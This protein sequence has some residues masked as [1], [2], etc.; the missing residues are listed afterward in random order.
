MKYPYY[1]KLIAAVSLGLGSLFAGAQALASAADGYPAKPIKISI[2]FP[3]GGSTDGPMRVLAE[4]ASR[5]L[6]Q[7]IVIENRTG[8]GG[9]LAALSLQSAASDGYTLAVAPIGIYRVP[10]VTNNKFDPTQDLTYVIGITGYA[11]GIVVPAS[12]PI[13]TIQ[14]YIDEARRNPGRLTYGTPGAATTNHLT[15]E[16]FSRLAGVELN[17]IPFKGSADSLQALLGGHVDSAAET[18]AWAPHVK[19]GQMRL[20]AVWGE[21]R[22]ASFP[23]APTLRE[24]GIDLVQTS[25]WG[26]VAPKGTDP[27]IVTKVHDAFRQA[28]Q[29]DAFK[30]ALAQFDMEPEYRGPQQYHEYAVRT[31]QEQKALLEELGLGN[32]P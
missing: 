29:T 21:K 20:L 7:P 19:A 31:T 15:M 16:Q 30:R 12:S 14:E 32:K 17:H 25:P 3:P 1:A 9:T 2:G 26:L 24:V 5:L 6:G 8:A 27:A 11:F 13:Q 10:F 22:M 18:S 4:Q 23:D 28:M